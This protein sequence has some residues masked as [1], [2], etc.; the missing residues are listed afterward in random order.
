[1]PTWYSN[2]CKHN[3]VFLGVFVALILLCWLMSV[4]V[5][6]PAG[7]QLL[8][9]PDVREKVKNMSFQTAVVLF[10]VAML[11]LFACANSSAAGQFV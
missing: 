1:M 2:A 8:P 5:Q 7:P 10:L 9:D 6:C 3:A 11:V 4:F